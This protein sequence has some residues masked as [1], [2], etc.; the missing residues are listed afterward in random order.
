M[1]NYLLLIFKSRRLLPS[2][3]GTKAEE[4]SKS[5]IFVQAYS[6]NRNLYNRLPLIIDMNLFHLRAYYEYFQ[7]VLKSTAHI[8]IDGD[9]KH[10]AVSVFFNTVSAVGYYYFQHIIAAPVPET[11][12]C[13]IMGRTMYRQ[14][15]YTAG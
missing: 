13:S 15:C 3:T 9:G 6:R 4:V 12:H 14:D 8:F 11:S 1:A 10:V 5:A 7:V 2:A